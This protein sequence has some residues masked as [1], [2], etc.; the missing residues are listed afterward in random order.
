MRKLTDEQ[1]D[2]YETDGYVVVRGFLDLN[3]DIQPLLDEYEE[4]LLKARP[5]MRAVASCVHGGDLEAYTKDDMQNNKFIFLEQQK[6]AIKLSNALD[7]THE[8]FVQKKHRDKNQPLSMAD[9]LEHLNDHIFPINSTPSNT[10]PGKVGLEL[11]MIAVK[12]TSTEQP[13]Q[14]TQHRQNSQLLQQL[15]EEQGWDPLFSTTGENEDQLLT[16]CH[17]PSGGNLSFEP[18]GQIE[19]SSRPYR[20]ANLIRRLYQ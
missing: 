12:T 9:C 7:L 16:L 3:A 11:E 18:G 13:P 6:I 17:I 15:A 5:V 14:A 8:D 20:Q 19:Y 1:L 2:Q 10:G 4:V